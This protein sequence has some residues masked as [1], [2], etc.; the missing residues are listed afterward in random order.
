M[1]ALNYNLFPLNAW[2]MYTWMSWW[3]FHLGLLLLAFEKICCCSY[4]FFVPFLILQIS[5]SELES[6]AT[7]AVDNIRSVKRTRWRHNAFNVYVGRLQNSRFFFSK[8]VKKSVKRA[9]RV[10]RA[11]SAR[12]SHARRACETRLS[13]G[14]ALALRSRSLFSASFQTFCLTARALRTWIRKNTDCFAV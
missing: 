3:Y 14:L 12:A 13:P 2:Q 9:V 8:S 11:R 1:K 7:L 4:F 10:L 5:R 6:F